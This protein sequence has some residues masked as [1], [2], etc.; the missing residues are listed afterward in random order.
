MVEGEPNS[1][2]WKFTQSVPI[3]PAE[4]LSC[5]LLVLGHRSSDVLILEALDLLGRVLQEYPWLTS[6]SDALV[7]RV[8]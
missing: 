3:L 8:M 1:P 5:R 2:T 7:I 6:A 4:V